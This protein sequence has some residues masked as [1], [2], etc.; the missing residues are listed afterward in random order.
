MLRLDGAVKTQLH[1]E[2]AKEPNQLHARAG[3]LVSSIGTRMRQPLCLRV[4]NDYFQLEMEDLA[5]APSGQSLAPTQSP[6]E[7][8][9]KGGTA[10]K[11]R[12]LG[13][14]LWVAHCF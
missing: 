5:T 1:P 6:G 9:V 2:G 14:D 4:L 3:W 12:S 11:E 13:K 7:A 10:C 8:G